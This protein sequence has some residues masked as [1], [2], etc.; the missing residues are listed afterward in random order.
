MGDGRQEL[1]PAEEIS[2]VYV[3]DAFKVAPYAT[4]YMH[5]KN[6]CVVG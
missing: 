3:S 6:N 5:Y 4:L 1:G 2:L